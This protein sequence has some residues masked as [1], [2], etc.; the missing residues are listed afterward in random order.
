VTAMQAAITAVAAL[1]AQEAI[2]LG[3][4]MS[5]VRVSAATVGELFLFML[6][7]QRSCRVSSKLPAFRSSAQ[8]EACGPPKQT[9]RGAP[10]RW[11]DCRSSAQGEACGPPK[12]TC[13]GAPSRW[14]DWRLRL[15]VI[16][17]MLRYPD[18]CGRWRLCSVGRKTPFGLDPLPPHPPSESSGLSWRS[19]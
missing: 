10:S 17:S 16:L 5:E 7:P 15:S 9:C 18:E 2:A 11:I 14:I 3:G 6:T 12:Q 8:G 1:G 19:R 13:R 4:S